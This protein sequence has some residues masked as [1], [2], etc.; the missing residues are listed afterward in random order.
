MQ[1]PS[2]PNRAPYTVFHG[3]L[4]VARVPTL[5]ALVAVL[6]PA[7]VDRDAAIRARRAAGEAHWFLADHPPFEVFDSQGQSRPDLCSPA[8]IRHQHGR[9]N[10]SLEGVVER[11]WDGDRRPRGLPIPGT[12]VRRS[13]G[14]WLV[15]PQTQA[16]R[17]WA[18]PVVEDGEPGVR[19]ARRAHMLPTAWDDWPKACV[20]DRSWKRHRRRQWRG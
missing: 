12:G 5:E 13:Y 8:R 19:A 14:R 3:G 15:F 4:F 11:P 9:R 10:G 18:C 6:S 17:R 1:S 20:E 16:E 7:W 2:S